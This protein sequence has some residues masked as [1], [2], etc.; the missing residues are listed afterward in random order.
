MDT[1]EYL[2]SRNIQRVVEL[3]AVAK[4]C[5]EESQNDLA[6]FIYSKPGKSLQGFVDTWKMQNAS[7]AIAQ[8]QTKQIDIICGYLMRGCYPSCDKLWYK[9]T[10]EVLSNNKIHPIVYTIALHEL[11]IHGRKKFPNILILGPTNCRKTFLLKP[12]EQIF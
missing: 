11:I 8:E 1:A 7:S 10:T 5:K 9:S 6:N 12:L 4:K 2:I 3:M